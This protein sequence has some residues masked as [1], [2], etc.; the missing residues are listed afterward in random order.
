ML[1]PHRAICDN[2]STWQPE[3]VPAL[4]AQNGSVSGQGAAALLIFM[5]TVPDD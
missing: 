4:P 3:S 5:P 1:L 2:L